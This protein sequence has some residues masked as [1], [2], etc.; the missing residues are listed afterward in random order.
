MSSTVPGIVKPSVRR[1]I[2]AHG[3]VQGVFFRDSVRDEAAARGISGWVRNCADGTVEAVFEGDPDAV[4]ALVA[5]CRSGP[6]HARVESVDV[7][8]EEPESL[9]G[10][11]VR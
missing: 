1:R 2:H 3:Q 9:A 5:F 10:F 11:D 6:G 7:V 8:T 4:D